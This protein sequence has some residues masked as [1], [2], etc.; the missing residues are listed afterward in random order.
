MRAFARNCL[1]T[2][3]A[4]LVLSAPAWAGTTGVY[5]PPAPVGSGGEDAIETSSGTRC[6][7]SMNNNGSYLDVGMTGS[8]AAPA[9]RDTRFGYN[10]SRDR[11]ATL[12]ARVTIPLGKRPDRIDCSRVYELEL[13]KLRR[14]VE[15]LRM[16]GQ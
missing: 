3:F 11:E 6:R 16:G 5:L 4:S 1:L 13:E 12:Y 10:D 2:G 15:L 8:A 7:Q 9:P 14:E